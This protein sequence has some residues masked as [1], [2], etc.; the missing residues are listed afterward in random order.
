MFIEIGDKTSRLLDVLRGVAALLVVAGHSRDYAA[1]IFKLSPTG[2][3]LFEKILLVPTS[4]AMESVAVFFVLSGFLV[5]GQTIKLVNK[6]QFIWSDFFAK[7]ISR[8]WVVLVPG[9]ILTW[10]V[11]EI[12][13]YLWEVSTRS[14]SLDAAVCN[15]FFFQE[16]QCDSFSINVALWSLSYEFWFYIVFAGIATFVGHCYRKKF[17]YAI[18][19]LLVAFI[20][21]AAFGLNLLFFMPSWLIGVFIYWFYA[22]NKEVHTF[23]YENN[24]YWLIFSIVL[25]T[26]F[27]LCSAFFSWNKITLTTLMAFPSAI[28][29]YVTLHVRNEPNFLTKLIDIGVYVGHRSFSI[30]VFHMPIVIFVLY[31]MRE[32][33][34]GQDVSLPILTYTTI[35]ISAPISILLWYV[36]EKHTPFFREKFL[37]I[38]SKSKNF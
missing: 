19:S 7:R 4:F 10:F 36:T 17:P 21:V 26:V 24:Y 5:G 27:A 32:L 8:L 15:L 30:Y 13:F 11:W 22:K 38:A 29:V 20:S 37:L 31:C 28:F 23:I 34:I 14:P 16:S 25:I 33:Y 2:D 35:I 12:N 6:D 18:V 3:S 9:I 1:K